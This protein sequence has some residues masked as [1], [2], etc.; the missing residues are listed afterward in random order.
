MIIFRTIL[1]KKIKNGYL[2]KLSYIFIK[3]KYLI[4]TI[5]RMHLVLQSELTVIM[6]DPNL[7]CLPINVKKWT[8][9]LLHSTILTIWTRVQIQAGQ[10]MII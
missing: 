7:E 3:V 5:I 4:K 6:Y 8:K 9:H 10:I 2:R 1:V